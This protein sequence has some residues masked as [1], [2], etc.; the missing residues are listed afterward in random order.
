VSTIQVGTNVRRPNTT[1]NEMS[2]DCRRVGELSRSV[3]TETHK[4]IQDRELKGGDFR[5]LCVYYH[6]FF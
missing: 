5:F 6:V 2:T 3:R 1:M 4:R